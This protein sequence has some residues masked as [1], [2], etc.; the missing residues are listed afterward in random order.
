MIEK[1]FPQFDGK[2]FPYE[3]WWANSVVLVE[4]LVSQHNMSLSPEQRYRVEVYV[5]YLDNGRTYRNMV[6]SWVTDPL[7]REMVDAASANFILL[8]QMDNPEPWKLKESKS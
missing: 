3:R 7:T 5:E 2:T 8:T 4:R 1:A 6:K